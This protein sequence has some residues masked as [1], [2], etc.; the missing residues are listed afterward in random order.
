MVFDAAG[1]LFFG[2]FDYVSAP[3]ALASLA[4]A[5]PVLT[6]R[7]SHCCGRQTGIAVWDPTTPMATQQVF[8]SSAVGMQ[9]VD[10]FAFGDG[11]VLVFTSNRLQLYFNVSGT[12]DAR[13]AFPTCASCIMCVG[14]GAGLECARFERSVARRCSC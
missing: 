5:R 10:T 12:P 4:T 8:V 11:D 1:H 9:W 3:H 14:K 6:L 13:R 7:V 2:I